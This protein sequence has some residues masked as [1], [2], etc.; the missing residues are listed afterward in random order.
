M[1]Q[2]QFR[3]ITFISIFILLIGSC[4]A[5]TPTTPTVTPQ[6]SM[7][8]AF[9][10][11]KWNIVE[12][13]PFL[14]FASTVED[15]QGGKSLLLQNGLAILKN[16]GLANGTIEFDLA[17]PSIS[18]ATGRT[19]GGLIFR[20]QD[21][22]NFE[23]FYLRGH[24]SGNPD[25]SQYQTF[26]N[27]LQSWQL[28]SPEKGYGSNNQYP[29][30]EFVHV[31]ILL[32]DDKAEM[33]IQDMA[34]PAIAVTLKRESAPGGVMLWALGL[35]VRFANFSFTKGMPILK[36]TTFKEETRLEGAVAS[37]SV[38]KAFP[39]KFLENKI[40]LEN[41]DK[42][43]LSWKTYDSE[44]SGLIN[45]AKVQGLV[46]DNDT[47]FAKIVISA[48]TAQIKKLKFGFNDEV[49][50]YLND[51]LLFSGNNKESSRDYRFLGTMGLF[52]ELYLPLKE[53]NNELCLA[54]TE[55]KMLFNGWGLQAQ[56]ENM[57]GI[58]IK[59]E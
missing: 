37:W 12:M 58:S 5:N 24:Q 27:G 34:T 1:K 25:A 32:A 11:E 15:F 36:A 30:N 46:K 42:Q 23:H 49:K 52:Y 29:L 4:S 54:V 13:M 57:E 40:A 43:G 48:K 28:Y 33:Y 56:F 47:V 55:D 6:N 59:A 44:G 14:P 50:V 9:D 26:F 7:I 2:I 39:Q 51:Q 45:L 10:P 8:P 38:S 20:A 22:E 35:P 18:L 31:K 16:E 21:S 41:A 53:G 19:M 3:I 17:F